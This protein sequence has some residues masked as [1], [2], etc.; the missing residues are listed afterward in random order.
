MNSTN[1]AYWVMG[2]FEIG[3]DINTDTLDGNQV[4]CIKKHLEMV[5]TYDKTPSNFCVWLKGF[6][7]GILI[8]DTTE[9][10]NEEMV[11]VLKQELHKIFKHEIDLTYGDNSMQNKLNSIH[12]PP[13]NTF[14]SSADGAVL[15]C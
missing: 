4:S 11:A 10:L 15:R 3:N 8:T 5:F 7:D 2:Y 12:N 6:L 9:G 14:P 13:H 1:F